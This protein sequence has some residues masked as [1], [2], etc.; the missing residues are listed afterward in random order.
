MTESTMQTVKAFVRPDFTVTIVC[1]SCKMP[2]TVSVSSFK[3]KTHYLKVRC[4]CETVFRVHLD[5]RQHYRKPTDLP[6]MYKSLK[7]TGSGGTIEVKDISISGLGFVIKGT[8]LVE[9]GHLLKV[10][11][12][13]DDKKKTKLE[14]KVVVQSI[15]NGFIGC[16]FVEE[17]AYE[18]ELGFYLKT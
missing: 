11:F 17:Q 6:G 1:P 9:E 12:E 2:K 8:N 3:N 18:K 4:P 5:F 16:K 15:T 13:L 14:K 10:S 7:P